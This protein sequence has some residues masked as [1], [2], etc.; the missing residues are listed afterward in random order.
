LFDS[1]QF[2]IKTRKDKW[3]KLKKI[4]NVEKKRFKSI[5]VSQNTK[6]YFYT[7]KPEEISDAE[8]CLS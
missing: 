1:S 5:E 7:V 6:K 2:K 8:L 4:E 3:I